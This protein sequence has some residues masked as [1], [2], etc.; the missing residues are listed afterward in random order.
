MFKEKSKVIEYINTLEDYEGY[1]QFS[2]REIEIKKDVF[3]QNN[4]NVK[5]EKGFILE[6]HFFNGSTSISIRQMN[7]GWIVDE[8]LNISLDETNIYDGIDNLQIRM[9]QIWKP[10]KDIN[11]ANMEVIKL[12]KVVFAGLSIKDKKGK[13]S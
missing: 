13:Q 11:C 6:A 8:C 7:E 10:K 4:P 2:H 1:V 12:E 5:D 3:I 9:A